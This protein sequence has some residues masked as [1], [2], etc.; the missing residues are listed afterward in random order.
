MSDTV[1]ALVSG[2]KTREYLD[3]EPYGHAVEW[4]EWDSD[5]RNSALQHRDIIIGV[6]DKEYLKQNRES[7]SAKAIGNYLESTYWEEQA[8]RE[9]QVINLKIFREGK[10]L[11]VSGIIQEQKIYTNSDN[12]QTLYPNGPTRISNDGFASPWSIWYEKF[13]WHASRF[14]NDKRWERSIIDNRRMLIEHHEWKERIDY[15]LKKY[16]GR[17]ADILLSDWEKVRGILEGIAYTDITDETLEYRKIGEQRALIVKEAAQKGYNT[18]IKS[19]AANIIPAFPAIDSIYGNVE[20]V[21]GKLIE[22]PAITFDQFINDL[23]KSYAVIGSEKDGYYFIHLNSKEMDVFF[24]TLFHYKSQVTPDVTE[25]F[26]FVAEILNEPAIL[27]YHGRAVTGVMV[28]TVAGMAG[29]DNVFIKTDN[30]DKNGRV[31]FE[32][33]EALSIFSGYKL[34]DAATPQQV[35]E[36]M[37]YYIKLGDMT[38][39]KKLF[40]NWKIYSEWEGPPYMD[41][42]FWNT[43]ESYQH[44]WEQSRRQILNDIYDVRVL[45]AGPIKTIVQQNKETGVPKVEQLRIIIDHIGKIDGKYKSLSNIYVHRNWTLQRLDN[46]PWK[47]TNLQAL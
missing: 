3:E 31:D 11:S 4:I 19:L 46:G 1:N 40:C 33:Q 25:R 26:K 30:P 38:A 9:G 28:K 44:T 27:S 47:I 18:F 10:L 37:I 15:L 39:W 5:F 35:I 17:F 34:D 21:A 2:I 42:T 14:L 45:Y 12:R 6:N 36:A 24:K 41:M 16:P 20:E 7:E 32:G 8:A 29:D 13:Q 23:G 43:E 22:L